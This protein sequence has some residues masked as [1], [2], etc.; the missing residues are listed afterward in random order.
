MQEY[1]E[2]RRQLEDRRRE[3]ARR[4]RHIQA[5]RRHEKGPLDRDM[6]EQAQELENDEVL[7]ALD[8]V[9]RRELEEILGALRRM[10]EGRYGVCRSCGEGI[11]M[12]RLRVRPVADTCVGCAD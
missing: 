3:I 10:D 8:G 12:A 6:E 11:P 1:G 9:E 4:V 7:D 2:L 5:D